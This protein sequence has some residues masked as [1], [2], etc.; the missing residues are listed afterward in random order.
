MFIKMYA[1]SC[2]VNVCMGP[3]PKL[4]FLNAHGNTFENILRGRTILMS[5]LFI[6]LD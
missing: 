5:R 2:H 4:V 3:A 6:L 1:W